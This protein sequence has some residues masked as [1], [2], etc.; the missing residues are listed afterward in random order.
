MTFG[1]LQ[2]QAVSTSALAFKATTDGSAERAE[3]LAE[4]ACGNVQTLF[5]GAY[6]CQNK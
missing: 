3:V 1:K 5:R 4:S 6:F 2:E